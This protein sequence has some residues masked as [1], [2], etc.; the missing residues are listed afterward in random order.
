MRVLAVDDDPT[1]RRYLQI[2]L[3]SEGVETDVAES[4]EVAIATLRGKPA[5]FYDLILL[6]VEMPS[7]SGWD[8]LYDLR[9]AG[10]E[11]P[12]IF[13][14]GREDVDDK[15]KGLGLG[16][17]D[18]VTKPVEISELIAR[19]QAVVRR[20]EN[21]TPLEYGELR[22]DLARRRVRRGDNDLELSPRE[23]DLL[24]TLVKAKGDI[25][26]R[27]SLL[28]EVWDMDFDPGTNILDVHIGRLR[29]KVDRQGRPLIHNE[30]GKGYRVVAHLPTE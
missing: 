8:L 28:S 7:Q 18:Y 6:D 11:T 12:V 27:Q 23:F 9:E 10:T 24:M 21:L 25:V 30:R 13:V 19:I 1:F 22:L 20:R 26:S 14:T 16:A 17:D 2:G 3:D 15:V 5:G 29:K 4:G